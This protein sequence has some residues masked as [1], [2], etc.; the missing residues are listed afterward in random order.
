MKNT[1]DSL[2]KYLLKHGI[3]NRISRSWAENNIDIIYEIAGANGMSYFFP[4]IVLK[5][6]VL[7]QVGKY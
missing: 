6:K 4:G 5:E 7:H 2:Y 3:F 1:I